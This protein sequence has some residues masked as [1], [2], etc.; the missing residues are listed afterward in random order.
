[1]SIELTPN[2][3]KR[4]T[5]AG[6]EVATVARCASMHHLPTQKWRPELREAGLASKL[7]YLKIIK[8]KGRNFK[9]AL[10]ACP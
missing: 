8:K 7:F 5:I 9:S 4:A 1:M 3:A 2:G 6:A 10:G